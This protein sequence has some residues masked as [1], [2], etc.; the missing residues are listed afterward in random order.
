MHRSI[1]MSEELYDYALAHG[2]PGPDPVATQLAATTQERFSDL[3]G[4]NIGQDQGRFLEAIV[5]LAR[6]ELVVE[7][8]TFTGMSALW[9]ARGLPPGGRLLCFEIS[10]RYLDT[11]TE[12]WEAAG[13]ADRIEMRLGPA[14]ER[15]AELPAEPHVD[16]AFI[17]ADKAGYRSYLDL[18]LPRVHDHGVVLVDNVLWS[19]AVIDESVDDANTRAIREFNDHVAARDDC[20]AVMLSIGD[21]VTVIR[22]RR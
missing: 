18:L 10:D 5:A 13:V 19:G 9:L 7:V 4:M 2:N 17:D 1:G 6:A 21:G 22:P 11:A 8:G 12:A 15:L 16:V 20:T 3:A 14:T